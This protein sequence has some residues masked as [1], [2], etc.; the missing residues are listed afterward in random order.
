MSTNIYILRLEGGKYYVGKTD[1]PTKRYNEHIAGK[2]SSWTKK[3]KPVGIEK[4]IPC[5]SPF[6]EDRYTKEW[7]SKYGI[8]NVRGGSYVQVDLGDEQV[9]MLKKELWGA[10]DAC[11]RCGRT[12]HFFKDCYARGDVSGNEIGEYVYGCEKCD[13]EFD[14][15]DECRRHTKICGRKKQSSYS[16]STPHVCYRCGRSGHYSP[17]CY[18]ST[19]KKGY[20]LD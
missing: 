16:T 13:K 14:N 5:A 8:E 6:D 4:I 7:M 17:D 18:A 15:E 19:H 10:K 2:G 20:L 3:Y 11:T 9:D 12:G 1:N